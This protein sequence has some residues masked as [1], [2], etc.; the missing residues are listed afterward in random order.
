MQNIEEREC[1]LLRW[2]SELDNRNSPDPDE[3]FSFSDCFKKGY[4][5]SLDTEP[6]HASMHEKSKGGRAL[7]YSVI[8]LLESLAGNDVL[9]E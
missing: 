8:P 6:W 2:A 5:D 4:E 3:D 9:P 1:A 7:L